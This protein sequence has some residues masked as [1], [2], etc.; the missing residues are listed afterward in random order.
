[1]KKQIKR[2][3]NKIK[4]GN[5]INIDDNDNFFDFVSTIVGIIVLLLAT[6]FIV[7]IFFTKEIDFK[8]KKET[9]KTEETEATIDNQTITAG[10]IFSK[11]DEKYYV[12]IYDVDSK[13]TN[14][15]V[16]VSKYQSTENALP[17]YVVDSSNKINSN[18]IVEKDS[19]TKPS[20]YSELKIKSPTLIKIENGKVT[21]YVEKEEEIKS[22]LKNE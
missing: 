22:I 14:L 7:G 6:Y 3:I 16:F 17:I 20:K 4:S 5:N 12:L 10:Q 11:K 8:K 21:S 2:N 13:L 1:M 9:T 19:N 18:F 15:G